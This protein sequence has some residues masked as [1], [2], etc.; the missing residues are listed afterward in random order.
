MKKSTAIIIGIL[1]IVISIITIKNSPSETTILL[2]TPFTEKNQSSI[3]VMADNLDFPTSIGMLPDGR[4]LLAEQKGV[5]TFLN[6]NGTVLNKY[7]LNDNYFNE[8]AGLLGLTISPKYDKNNYFYIYYTYKNNDKIFNKIER[9]QEKNSTIIDKKIIMDEIPASQLHNGG[10]LKFGPDGKLYASVGDNTIS[11]SAQNLSSL[12][13]KILRID[14]DGTIPHDNPFKNSAIYSYGHR[15]VVGLAWDFKNKALY[16][17]EPG[18]TG[19]DEINIIKPGQNYG[20]PIEE[21]GNLE[22]SQFVQPEFCFT[23]SIYPSGMIISNSTKLGYEGK[24]IVA[25]LKGEHLRIIDLNSKDQSTILTGF[26]KLK[27]VTEDKKGSLYI[28][29]GNKDFYQ[30]SGSDKLLKII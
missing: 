10:V 26:G 18:A 17:S 30:D 29:T 14:D 22:K 7:K 23:P 15:N 6:N 28:I 1:I 16:A 9:L 27:D 21:C 19:N 12:R 5:I 24:L 25:T 8:G 13:G 3:K 2:P 4:I 11:E 20:W